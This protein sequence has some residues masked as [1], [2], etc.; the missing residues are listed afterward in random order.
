MLDG[1]G[2]AID[3]I[4]RDESYRFAASR[5]CDE[6]ALI[7]RGAER[8]AK[9]RPWLCFAFGRLD[10]G[11]AGKI[12]EPRIGSVVR[13]QPQACDAGKNQREGDPGH[14]SSSAS[15]SSTSFSASR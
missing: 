6:L 10:V 12:D 2:S 11:N 15:C 4:F 8:D 3:D 7:H 14:R 13:V 5:R 1:G 9:H